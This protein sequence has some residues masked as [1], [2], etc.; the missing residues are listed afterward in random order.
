MTKAEEIQSSLVNR[1]R[2]STLKG[3][4][5]LLKIS[6]YVFPKVPLDT[7]PEDLL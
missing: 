3:Q 6:T 7:N 5:Y 2:L 4:N 1:K